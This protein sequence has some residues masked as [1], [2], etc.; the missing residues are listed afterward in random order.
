MDQ[1]GSVAILQIPFC[2]HKGSVL[3]KNPRVSDPRA[4]PALVPGPIPRP[5]DWVVTCALCSA[6]PI[7][8]YRRRRKLVEGRREENLMEGNLWKEEEAYKLDI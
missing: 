2:L 1:F 3:H 8:A 4:E 5:V 6:L 7:E